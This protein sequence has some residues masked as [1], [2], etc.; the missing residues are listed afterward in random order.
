MLSLKQIVK[1]LTIFLIV[2]GTIGVY[3]QSD[4]RYDAEKNLPFNQKAGD[5]NPQT[6]TI[7]IG[8]GDV[9]LPGRA[10]MNFSFGRS[11]N[12]NQ[13]NVYHMYQDINDGSNRLS[14]DTIERVNRMGIGWSTNLPYIMEDDKSGTL[15]MS[16]FMGGSVFNIDYNATTFKNGPVGNDNFSNLIGYDLLNYRIYKDSSVSYTGVPAGYGLS[17]TTAT[18][19]AYVLILKDNSRFYFREDGK[20]MMHQDKSGLNRIWYY[21]EDDGMGASRLKVVVDTVNR[22]IVFDYDMNGNLASISWEVTRGVKNGEERTRE[23]ITKTVSY[24]YETTDNYPEIQRV[25][26]LVNEDE[27]ESSYI[28]TAMTD[29]LGNVTRY[30]YEEGTAAF[31]FNA[32]HS[33]FENVYL[34]LTEI[35]SFY[36][37]ATGNYK[38]KRVLEYDVPVKGMPTKYFYNGFMEYYKLSGQYYLDKTGR[39]FSRTRYIYYDREDMVGGNQYSTVIE[40]KNSRMT[41]FYSLSDNLS[42]QHVLFS[43]TVE[44]DD[45]FVE[46]RDFIYDQNRAKVQEDVRRGGKTIYRETF[47]YDKKGNL[48]RSTDKMGLVTY[49]EY[50][51]KYSIPTKQIRTVTVDGLSKDYQTTTEINDKGQVVSQSIYLEQADGSLKEVIM[52]TITYDAYGNPLTQ[53]DAAGNTGYTVYD[54]E[55]NTFPVK[56]YQHVSIDAWSNGQDVHANWKTAPD[57]PDQRV[58]IR[59]W[60]VFNSDGTVWLEIDNEGY[61]VEHYYDLYGQEIE[62]VNPD[63]DDIINFATPIKVDAGDNPLS[64]DFDDFYTEYLGGTT[65]PNFTA[66]FTAR[67]HNPGARMTI[68]YANDHVVTESDIE[69]DATG[70]SVKLGEQESNGLGMVIREAEIGAGGVKYEKTMDYDELGRMIALHDPDAEVLKG[71]K[72]IHDTTVEVYDKTWI[73]YYDDLGRKKMVMYPETRT[74]ITDV[75]TITYDDLVNSVTTTDPEGRT[76]T[77]EMD[78]NGNVVK[79]TH[80]GNALTQAD[81]ELVYTYEYD[82][83]KRK[84]KFTDP[85]GIVT[86]YHYDERNLLLEQNYGEGTGSDFMTYNDLGQLISKTDRKGN[87]VEMGYDEMGRNTEAE[88]FAPD[89]D[90]TLISQYTIYLSYD[91]RGNAV[92]VENGNLI[93]HYIYD[94]GNRAISLERVLKDTDIKNLIASKLTTE[95]WANNVSNQIFSFNYVYNDAGMVTSMIYPDGK[96]HEFG[97]DTVLGRLQ[98]IKEDS[99]NFVTGMTYNNSGVVTRMEYANSTYQSWDFDNRKRINTIKIGNATDVLQDLTYTLNG[100]G[101]VVKINDNEYRYDGFNRVIGAKTLIPGMQDKTKLVLESFGTYKVEGPLDVD[102]VER[103]FNPDA[104]MNEDERINGADLVLASYTNEADMYDNEEF[105]YDKNGNRTFLK[106][107]G[108]QYYYTY[109]VRNRLEKIEVIYDDSQTKELF[110]EYEYDANGNTTKRTIYQKDGGIQV[111][112]FEYD[113]MNRLVKTVEDKAGTLKTT[114]YFYDNAGNRFIKKTDDK[115]TVY[116]RHGQIA[117]AM[118]LELI[119]DDATTD[120][121]TV[122]RYVLS[123]DLLAGRITTEYT[124]DLTT[125]VVTSAVERFWYHLDHLNS[126]KAVTKADGTLDVVYEYRAF[127]EELKK[128]GEGDAKY[129]YGGKELDGET[130]LYYFNARYY[131]ATIGRFINVDPIQDGTN[132]YVYCGNNPLNMVDPTGLDYTKSTSFWLGVGGTAASI[133]GVVVSVVCPPAA[134]AAVILSAASI[135][136]GIHGITTAISEDAEMTKQLAEQVNRTDYWKGKSQLRRTREAFRAVG[137]KWENQESRDLQEKVFSEALELKRSKYAKEFYEEHGSNITRYNDQKVGDYIRETVSSLTDEEKEVAWSEFGAEVDKQIEFLGDDYEDFVKK[138]EPVQW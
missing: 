66:Y 46:R 91:N 52:S 19:S 93:E 119:H 124:K 126:T 37:E 81:E 129:T 112:T 128:L 57:A 7:T 3:G 30:T 111:I 5:V 9:S 100:S 17:D 87:T 8:A 80:F 31:T 13:S 39:E 43:T 106:Q 130:N 114:E 14:T 90:N 40:T 77:E 25:F 108:D 121:A 69:R 116:L 51:E 71:V 18:A 59:S 118:D 27:Q 78:W 131:D 102:G 109:G 56:I 36:D 72:T 6:G 64:A 22:E 10:G 75:K 79:F 103:F 34:L 45:G 48:R 82:E 49:Q 117:V 113:T 105:R 28:L 24:T 132:W 97:Y 61:A 38:S 73:V 122:N 88:E 50:D 115:T 96:V 41:Y 104:D 26:G 127:G 137:T 63:L 58:R 74:G 4:N 76:I 29:P 23:T 101:D 60:K 86:T 133:A 16:L 84:V 1:Y 47:E 135:T 33:H 98:T 83:L 95:S 136:T 123:G 125:Q 89:A 85:M 67:A 21:Y 35:T 44:T 54:A 110:A 94:Y 42:L 32:T 15:V 65:D 134:L 53:T 70:A 62:T 107:N 20:I 11:W 120:V 12:L 99:V 138:L 55:F 92:R 2:L 68:D